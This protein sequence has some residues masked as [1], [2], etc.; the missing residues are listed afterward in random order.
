MAL[1]RAWTTANPRR[2]ATVSRDALRSDFSFTYVNFTVATGATWRICLV[3]DLL[4]HSCIDT[5][6]RVYH[7]RGFSSIA[8]P[9]TKA[10]LEAEDPMAAMDVFLQPAELLESER[11]LLVQQ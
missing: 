4:T 5:D 10:L 7:V 1:V 9:T 6:N 3:S 11:T 8:L 2:R